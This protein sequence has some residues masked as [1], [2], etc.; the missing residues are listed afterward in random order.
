M[1]NPTTAESGFPFPWHILWG[2][3]MGCKRILCVC[4]QPYRQD[5]Q[6]GLLI[7]CCRR[8]HDR[9][10]RP[11]RRGTLSFLQP[12][13]EEQGGHSYPG[14]NKTSPE[15]EELVSEIVNLEALEILDSRGNPTV[16]VAATLTSGA[17][18]LAR[19]PRRSATTGRE[20]GYARRRSGFRRLHRAEAVP[21]HRGP[22]E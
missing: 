19:G 21:L 8:G 9:R 20:R 22:G 6:P 2:R 1:N 4:R 16:Q 14:E 13:P 18:G 17:R 5:L 11:D 3:I 10:P 15:P 12:T 7:G